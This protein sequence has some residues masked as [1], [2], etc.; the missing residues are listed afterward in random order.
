MFTATTEEIAGQ[1]LMLD[2][3]IIGAPA[4]GKADAGRG[5]FTFTNM[6]HRHPWVLYN[7]ER[8]RRVIDPGAS[9][10]RQPR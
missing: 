3:R 5:Q 9:T 8:L 7:A 1:Y 10:P 2:D 6:R 4:P